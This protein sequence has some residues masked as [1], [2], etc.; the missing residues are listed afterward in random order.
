MAKKVA[1]L[2]MVLLGLVGLFLAISALA[3]KTSHV[4]NEKVDGLDGRVIRNEVRIEG[5]REDIADIKESQKSIER[6]LDAAL[7]R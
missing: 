1:G 5:V 2:T 3:F 6:K 4:A 7:K